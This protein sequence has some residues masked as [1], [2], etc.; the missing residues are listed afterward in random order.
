MAFVVYTSPQLWHLVLTLYFGIALIYRYESFVFKPFP[1]IY[2]KL[3]NQQKTYTKPGMTLN[4]IGIKEDMD[5]HDY[6]Y[7]LWKYEWPSFPLYYE[8]GKDERRQKK[9]KIKEI[10]NKLQA[11]ILG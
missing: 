7:K 11:E 4:N 2:A 1:S 10:S 5:G 9:K 3:K 8:H 6:R